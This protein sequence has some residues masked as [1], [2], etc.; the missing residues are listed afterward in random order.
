MDE[1]KWGFLGV[2]FPKELWLNKDLNILEK[3]IY[4]EIESLDN[5]D[6]H[7]IASNKYFA[8]FC[9]CSESKVSKAIKKLQDLNMVEVLSFD[10]RHR[11]L[12][13]TGSLVKNARQP[14]KKCEADQQILPSINIDSSLDNISFN[15]PQKKTQKRAVKQFH[16]FEQRDYN[17]DELEKKMLNR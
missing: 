5:G 8:E 11:Q 17:Y 10:G 12:A 1:Q 6:R 14:S 3:A 13:V 4:I 16:N 15:K 7:C 2:W 9:G